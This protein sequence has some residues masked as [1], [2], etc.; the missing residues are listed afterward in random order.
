M[1]MNYNRIKHTFY[2]QKVQKVQIYESSQEEVGEK[3]VMDLD[4]LL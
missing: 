2:V 4:F 1:G 3:K